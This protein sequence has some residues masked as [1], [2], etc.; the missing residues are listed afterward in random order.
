[1]PKPPGKQ[2]RQIQL[3]LKYL[4]E[5]ISLDQGNIREGLNICSLA[6]VMRYSLC[7]VDGQL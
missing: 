7:P 5:C 6:P 2:S 3:S 4:S 1:V